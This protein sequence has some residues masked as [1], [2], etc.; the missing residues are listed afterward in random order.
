MSEVKRVVSVS[1]GSSD[2]DHAVE[3]E[4]LGQRFR[5]ERIGT[6]GDKRRAVELIRSLDGRVA[7]FGM[8]GTDLY[9]WAGRK[10]LVIRDALALLRAARQTPIVDG[11]GL[12]NTLERRVVRWLDRQGV[13]P[14]RGR[15]VLMTSAVDRFGMAEAL[16]EAGARVTFGDLAFILGIPVPLRSLRA[17]E[18]IGRV[19]GP[20]VTQLPIAW[21]YPTGG[22]QRENRP[23]LPSWFAAHEVIAGDFHF[24]RRYMPPRLD[25]KVVLTNTVTARDVEELRR[26]GARMLVTT[27]PELGGRSFGTNVMEALLVAAS[28]RRPEELTP[29]DYEE[30]LD[31]LGFE[32]RVEVL[33][34]EPVPAGVR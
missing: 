21:L 2:R 5:V 23:R 19:I 4:V 16:V 29:A 14:L 26:R 3:V 15:T 27:T 17:L 30:L 6:D 13:L 34:G 28:G 12:K 24:I 10:R 11:S 20:V 1:L 8:G 9:V 18:W 25:G 33:A 32:P 31:R 7:A 22:K